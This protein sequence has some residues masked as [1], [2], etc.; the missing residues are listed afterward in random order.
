MAELKICPDC[1]SVNVRAM[2]SYVTSVKSNGW[3]CHDCKYGW[4]KVNANSATGT[5]FIIG[6]RYES[7]TSA[8]G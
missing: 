6:R 3:F 8:T 1:G 2:E 4:T 5:S 7:S